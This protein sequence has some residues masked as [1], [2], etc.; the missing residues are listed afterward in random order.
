VASD[1]KTM[2]KPTLIL[3]GEHDAQ[4]PLKI[5]QRLH[6]DIPES[7]LVIVPNAG[8]MILV[9]APDDV[10]RAIDDFVGRL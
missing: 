2:R 3:W 8:H 7:R 4:M 6:R 10:A 5:A 1:L 9:D